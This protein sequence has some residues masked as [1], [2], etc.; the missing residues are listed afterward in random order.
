MKRNSWIM[1]AFYALLFG[2]VIASCGKDDDDEFIADDATFA[3]FTSWTL[4]ATE[5]GVDPSGALG[6][7]HNGEAENSI[8][9][10][11]VKDGLSLSDGSYANGTVIV[12]HTSNE[13]GDVN[14][15]QGMVKRG[16]GFNSANSDWEWF[17]LNADGTIIERGDNIGA[18][19]GC[20]A[21]SP[22]D[23]VFTE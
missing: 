17:K 2:F 8:R 11:Y 19:G 12:K 22:R 9:R 21:A 6:A 5:T 4:K 23:Y 16:N 20:H 1:A 18:C 7:A 14:S 15:Y 13:P 10:I 3:N